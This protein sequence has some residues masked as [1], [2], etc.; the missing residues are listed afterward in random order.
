MWP[1]PMG[2]GMMGFPIFM[3]L[4]FVI[5]IIVFIIVLIDILKR[6]DLDTLKKILWILVVWFL[7]IIGAII[8]YLLSKR[9]P[10][11]DNN[12]KNIGSN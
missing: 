5:S 12:G 3:G 2:F 4:W 1:C 7:G 9:N 10:K 8:Y 6:D 11:G